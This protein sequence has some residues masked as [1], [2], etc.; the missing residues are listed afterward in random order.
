DVYKRQTLQAALSPLAFAFDFDGDGPRAYQDTSDLAAADCRPIT[1]LFIDFPGENTLKNNADLFIKRRDASALCLPYAAAA[2]I[3]LQTYAPSGGAG[4]R[5]SIRGGGPLTTLVAPRRRLAG[6]GEVATLWDR[7]WANVPDQKWDGSDPIA[8]DPADHANW[9]LVFPWLAAAIT[10]SHGQIVA[11]A[12]ATKRQS[13]FGCPRRLRLVF[14]QASPDHPCVLGGPAGAIMAVGFRTQNYGANYEGWTHPLSP[15]RDDKKAGRLP[16]HPHGGAATYGDWLAIWGYDGTPAVGVEIWD[17]RRALLG[18][19]LAG[20]AIEAFGFDM[21]NAKARQW[22]DIRL[23]WVGVYGEDAATL[24]TAIAQMIGATQKASQRLRLAIRLA[25]WGQRATDPKT[26]KPGFRLPDELPA[27]AATIDVTPIWQETEGPFRR[28]VQDLIA[29]P[30]GHLAV[31]KLWLKTLRGQTLRQF[32]TTVDLDG[33]TDADPHRLLF[34]RD[35]LSR[36]LA[37]WSEV[38]KTLDIAEPKNPKQPAKE[39]A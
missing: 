10:S 15:Y 2:T 18:A 24:R 19:T 13:F 14:Q 34:A 12:D 21:D 6:G 5:T 20:D 36:A 17:R 35:G 32:D 29:K 8:G 27:D 16:I 26:G 4:H 39:P 1:G 31:R 9:P 3:T 30:D 23:P 7:I 38:A 11:P 37:P 28:H 22:L 25:L 33:L